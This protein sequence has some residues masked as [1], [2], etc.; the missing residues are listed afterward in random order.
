MPPRRNSN[1]SRNEIFHS[2]LR[3][4]VP[5]LLVSGL[6][7][8]GALEIAAYEKETV[9]DLFPT[10]RVLDV[11]ITVAEEDWDKIRKQT[12]NFYE[13]LQASRKEKPV[14]GPYVYVNAA[15]TID[16]IEFPDVGLRKKGFIGS[17]NSNR[18]SLKIKLN[19]VDKK[20]QL[21]GQT[22][23][24]FNNNNQDTS[25]M[26]Q[27]MGY[28]LFNAA[29]SPAP[30][31]ALARLTVNG[32]NLG[33]YSHVEPV[34]K[35]LLRRG[36]GN[37]RGT[38]YEGTVTDFFAGW[39]G[40]FE[41]KIGKDRRARR[42]IRQLIEVLQGEIS[43][44][45]ILGSQ[46]MGRGWV[47]AGNGEDASG[48]RAVYPGATND[49]SLKAIEDR[50][51]S[52]RKTQATVTPKL[53]AEQKKWKAENTIQSVSLSPWSVIGPFQA[54]SFDEAFKHAFPPEIEIDLAK[55]YAKDGKEI[56]DD[57][58][59][60]EKLSLLIVDG[61]NN[62][63]W[64][65]TTQVLRAFLVRTG[66]FSVDVATSPGPK[67]T[68]AAW[69]KFRP[70]F[71]KFDVVLSN[72]NGQ[73]WPAPVQAALV[74]YIGEGG[75]MVNVHAANNAFPKWVEFNKMIGLGWRGNGDGN[76]ITIDDNGKVVR[77]PKGQ[78]PG[79]GRGP[80]HS[81]SVVTRDRQHPVMRGIPA[82]W[83]HFRD[84]L[85]HGL[86]GPA[87]NIQILATAY[88]AK[89]KSGTSAH[90]PMVWWVS[91]GK[92]RVFTTVM[93]HGDY[94]M[95]C[96][97][98]QT[99]VGRGAEWAATGKVTLPIPKN[100]PTAQK[101]SVVE[102][103]RGAPLRW[104]EVK[105][106]LDG[107][108][109]P[110]SPQPFSATY[111]FR[112]ITSPTA[113]KLPAILGSDDGIKLWLNGK[114]QFEKQELRNVLPAT[115]RTELNLLAGEN[116]ILMKIINSGGPAGLFFRPLQKAFPPPVLAALRVP[117]GDRNKGQEKVLT[118]YYLAIAPSLQPIRAELATLAGQ[119]Y[120]HWTALD[121]D[122]SSWTAG[123]NGAGYETGEGFESLISEPFDFQVDMFEKS[124]SMY[125]RFPFEL[126]DLAAVRGDLILKLK[127]D[128]GFVAYLNGHRI[129]SANAPNPIRW[130]SRATRGHDDPQALEF[131]DFNISEHRDKFRKGKNVLAIHGLNVAPG[132]T[133][134]LILPEIQVN[135][136]TMEQAIGE[137]VD[138]DAFYRFWAI[139]GLLGFWDGYSA[140]RN[141]FFIY[142]NPDSGKFHF[143]PWG[144]DC[145]FEKRSRLRVDPRAPISVKTMGRVAHKLY[146]VKSV[147]ERYLKTLKQIM[148]E[149]WNEE[150]LIAETHRIEAMLKPG[151]LAPSQVRAMPGKLVGLRQFINTRRVE[152]EKETADG[153]PIW[154][155][156]P[157]PPP[158]LQ[159]PNGQ[160]RGNPRPGNAERGKKN[161]GR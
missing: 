53:A 124:T 95:K 24:T 55:S 1:Q 152:I 46:T 81:F 10:D 76:R 36:F 100:F 122:A 17:Q 159:A 98:F 85:Y 116:R 111:L 69:G 66:R 28:A 60:A 8:T 104:V 71:D 42:K 44:T 61:Q 74:K 25:Q 73:A 82:E 47:P 156:A 114:L 38:V 49:A 112:T 109:F 65:A 37:D 33:V 32:K 78:G 108:P 41:R 142:L 2:G 7:I 128:D 113:R 27:F 87:L 16:G 145:M 158:Q 147:R 93:G 5:L 62:H 86:R 29:G 20:A 161:A 22:V 133:D 21:G 127:Y 118:D 141:N 54:T 67:G 64:R 57:E 4:L 39:E 153:M 134:M 155:A 106:I 117:A 120:E 138:L 68:D 115:D 146:Q 34:R 94:S 102:N 130:N 80:E 119:H 43:G 9:V 75:A 125:L 89:D 15:V 144:G 101:T 45:T 107:R 26:S 91:Y 103:R 149:H 72:Y 99:I 13:A 151:D 126:E 88:S 154:K 143:L 136:I 92:G 50:I 157:G 12:R 83:M 160:G 150:Q 96:V 63:N 90:E 14:K 140:N 35:P 129:A 132:S 52:L 6:C 70:A 3:F 79:A 137:L 58:K 135:D 131:E 84:E 18:P 59:S 23:L 139:E 123:R 77:T 19:L 121:F 56:K 148:A 48:N 110:L 31:C 40:S 30:R 51:A 11:Q 105:S 97:G